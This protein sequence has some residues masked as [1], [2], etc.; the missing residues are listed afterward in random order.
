MELKKSVIVLIALIGLNTALLVASNAGGAKLIALP[1][2]LAASATVFSYALS[3]MFT[4]IISELYGLKAAK[5]AVYV[6]FGGLI[7]AVLFFVISIAAPPAP[8]WPGQEGYAATLGFG[9]RL[10]LGGWT[11]YMVS[12]NLDVWIFH[13]LKEM[14]GGRHLW[15]RNNAS[16]LVSQFVDT[17][18]F[19]TIAFYGTFPIVEAILGQYLLKLVIAVLDTPLVYLAVRYLRPD[20]QPA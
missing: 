20:T 4:D 5:L 10:L 13:K 12:Q 6:G 3:F 19:I 16:T 15:L 8:F 7:L 14:T 9:P 17:C 2:G 18:I 1:F 11:S